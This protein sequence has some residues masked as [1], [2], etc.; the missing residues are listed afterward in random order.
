[1][2]NILFSASAKNSLVESQLALSKAKNSLE[3]DDPFVVMLDK[4]WS[5]FTY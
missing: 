3:Q 1:M 5:N 2:K 4:M